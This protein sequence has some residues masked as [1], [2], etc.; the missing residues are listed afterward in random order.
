MFDF[1]YSFAKKERKK[2]SS[3]SCSFSPA[4]NLEQNRNLR[5]LAMLMRYISQYFI[6]AFME[7]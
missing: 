2:V 3:N 6:T 7:N 1:A 4:E 5:T